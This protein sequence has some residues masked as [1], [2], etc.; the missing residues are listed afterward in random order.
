MAFCL[1]S[2]YMSSS[3]CILYHIDYNSIAIKFTRKLE[4]CNSTANNNCHA[5][6]Q[7]RSQPHSPGWA[8]VSLSSF[9]PQISINFVLFFLKLYLFSS[10]F[11]P[12]PPMGE[13]PTRKG[14]GY[15]IACS[16]ENELVVMLGFKC[17]RNLSFITCLDYLTE[18]RCWYRINSSAYVFSNAT[19]SQVTA[20]RKPSFVAS[21]QVDS[22]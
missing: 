8:R 22:L 18:K 2:T 20:Q 15:A 9:F 14:P 11:C 21:G 17:P 5:C 4:R 16:L 7:G 6:S 13:S 19:V 1:C 12:P 10:S 3:Y